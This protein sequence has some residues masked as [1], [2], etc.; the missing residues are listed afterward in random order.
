M[1]VLELDKLE[2]ELEIKLEVEPGLVELFLS[3]FF[4]SKYYFS[5]L[6]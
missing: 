3:S 4:A 6:S 2:L 1:L 5:F